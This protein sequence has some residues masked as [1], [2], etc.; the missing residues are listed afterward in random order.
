MTIHAFANYT[1]IA[2]TTKPFYANEFGLSGGDMSALSRFGLIRPTGNSKEV[3]VPTYDNYGFM[4]EAKEWVV[5]PM[6]IW[7]K[8]SLQK[9]LKS[10]RQIVTFCDNHAGFLGE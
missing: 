5:V 6:P 2:D 8:L 7:W 10:A 4:A 3:F 9:I 1:K